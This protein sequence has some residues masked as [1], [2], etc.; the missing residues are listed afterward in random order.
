MSEQR[1]PFG[2]EP[3]FRDLK[4][5]WRKP[6]LIN[7]EGKPDK[8]LEDLIKSLLEWKPEKRL[9]GGKLA[10]TPAAAA[11]VK[12]HKYWRDPDWEL[13]EAALMPSPLLPYVEECAHKKPS[14]TKLKKQQ[15]AAVETAVRMATI[16][17]SVAK[18][19]DAAE[20]LGDEA[21]RKARLDKLA[22]RAAELR[23]DGWDFVSPHA[24]DAEY[25]ETITSSVSLL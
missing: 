9:G 14:D 11:E 12:A 10:N 25:V 3:K 7:E 23:I 24:I 17:A 13:V 2:D 5:E 20:H 21:E 1:L 6:R 8:H 16:E 18:A 4:S 15:R 19:R 22:S